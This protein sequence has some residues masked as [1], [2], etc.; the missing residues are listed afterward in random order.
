LTPVGEPEPST[1]RESDMSG[2][3]TSGASDQD[4]SSGPARGQ[5][6]QHLADAP[7]GARRSVLLLF[8]VHEP[9][10]GPSWR[11]RMKQLT[12]RVYRI[13]NAAGP[14]AVQLT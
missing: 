12:L 2:P 4:R 3:K 1:W 6:E 8:E 14:A 5:T 13:F 10:E 11:F 7:F 9:S